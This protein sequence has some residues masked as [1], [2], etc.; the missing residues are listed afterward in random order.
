MPDG[1]SLNYMSFGGPKQS[2]K[3]RKSLYL[4]K[5]I[6]QKAKRFQ[7]AK[8]RAENKNKNLKQ[9]SSNPFRKDTNMGDITVES[10]YLFLNTY[11][12]G[13][14]ISGSFKCLLARHLSIYRPRTALFIRLEDALI[15]ITKSYTNPIR[16]IKLL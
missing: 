8:K 3:Q 12:F 7:K 16:G 5:L 2:K 11:N 1:N 13:L 10:K 14:T 9:I 4:Q 6:S 15:T